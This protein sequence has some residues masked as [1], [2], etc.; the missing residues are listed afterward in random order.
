MHWLTLLFPIG[1]VVYCIIRDRPREQAQMKKRISDSFVA[2]LRCP[3]TGQPLVTDWTI[4]VSDEMRQQLYWPLTHDIVHTIVT[5]KEPPQESRFLYRCVEC[6]IG[7]KEITGT[8]EITID[9]VNA[10]NGLDLHY[11]FVPVKLTLGDDGISKTW[12]VIA[13][14][15]A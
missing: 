6:Q 8:V 10:A 1:Y 11:H 5:T 9:Y 4:S 15:H 12:A 3:Q 2:L 13:V 7:R 14:E